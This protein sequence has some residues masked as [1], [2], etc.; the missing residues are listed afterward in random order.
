V[1]SIRFAPLI[2]S[3]LGLKKQSTRSAVSG[4]TRAQSPQNSA[5]DCRWNRN[6]EAI[7]PNDLLNLCIL[8]RPHARRSLA[9]IAIAMQCF[10]DMHAHAAMHFFFLV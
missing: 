3:A 4:E 5:V 2:R 7:Y 1:T 8:S 10:R 9:R 6:T